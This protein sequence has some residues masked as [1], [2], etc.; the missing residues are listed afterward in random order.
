MRNNE[1]SY[2]IGNGGI[3]TAVYE[4]PYSDYQIKSVASGALVITRNKISTLDELQGVS[5]IKFSDGTYNTATGGFVTAPPV[6]N[7]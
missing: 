3:D 1:G 2:V 6:G 5:F 7:R 4:G